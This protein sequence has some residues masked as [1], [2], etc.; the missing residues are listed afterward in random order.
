[1]GALLPDLAQYE[2]RLSRAAIE[3]QP[4]PVD[5]PGLAAE[6]LGRFLHELERSA[7]GFEQLIVETRAGAEAIAN[8][9]NFFDAEMRAGARR[10]EIIFRRWAPRFPLLKIPEDH[11]LAVSFRKWIRPYND[12]LTRLTRSLVDS[13]AMVKA[14]IADEEVEEAAANAWSSANP[15]LVGDEETIAWD[16]LKRSLQNGA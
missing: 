5:D 14:R 3:V 12:A 6:E 8:A 9:D 16:E 1:M 7:T 11:P 4:A 15:P 13:A 2:A 10:I